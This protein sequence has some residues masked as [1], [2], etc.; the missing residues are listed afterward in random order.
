MR[1]GFLVY[2][3]GV[4]GLWGASALNGWELGGGK[5]GLIPQNVRQSPGGYRS[6]NYW[7]GGK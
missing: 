2:A 7:R 5:R 3:L 6:Y 1:R 4:L